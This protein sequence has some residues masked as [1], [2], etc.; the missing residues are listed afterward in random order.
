MRRRCNRPGAARFADYGG[1]GITVCPRWDSFAAFLADMGPAPSREHSIDRVDNS[2]GYSPENCRWATAAEQSRNT[3][4]TRMIT[5]GA[6]TLCIADW[7]AKVGIDAMSF[8]SRLKRGWTGERLLQG[9][10][11]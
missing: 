6:E 2:K 7:A 11:R 5:I 4:R 3:R 1:R 10:T 9:R 8:K